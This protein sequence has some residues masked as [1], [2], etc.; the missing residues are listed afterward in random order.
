[1]TKYV[2]NGGKTLNGEVTISGAKNAAVAIVPAALLADGPV[3]LENVPKIIDVTLQM[4]I[5]RELGAQIRQINATTVEIQ[6]TQNPSLKPHELE[7]KLR[8]GVAVAAPARK[9]EAA[10]PAADAPE[11]AQGEAAPPPAKEAPKGP[12]PDANASGRRPMRQAKQKPQLFGMLKFGGSSPARTGCSPW[13]IPRRWGAGLCEDA[14]HP[15]EERGG[16]GLPD[17]GGGLP[18][19]VPRG[20]RGHGAGIGQ[21]NPQRAGGSQKAGGKQPE[22]G[23]RYVRPGERA[24]QG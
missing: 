11:A 6:N 24:R 14:E 12:A 19:Y 1:M 10:A 2:I 23:I 16:G 21:G 9:Q 22:Q 18:V 7:R 20:D 5:M 3:R 15:G 17:A 8:E 4:E 13:S